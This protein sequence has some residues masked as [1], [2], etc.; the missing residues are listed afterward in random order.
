METYREQLQK[1]QELESADPTTST[2]G[3][4]DEQDDD[5]DFKGDLPPESTLDTDS[6]GIRL[7]RSEFED[8]DDEEDAY[9]PS[10]DEDEENGECDGSESSDN[11]MFKLYCVHRAKR[12]SSKQE[13]SKY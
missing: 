4:I 10:G 7:G 3:R 5:M 8:S 2:D 12:E 13:K 6:D 1:Q 9:Q 11:S